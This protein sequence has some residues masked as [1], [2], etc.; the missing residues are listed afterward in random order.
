MH[1]DVIWQMSGSHIWLTSQHLNSL[2]SPTK[3]IEQQ[4]EK[5][6]SSG[7]FAHLCFLPSCCCHGAMVIIQE[8]NTGQS[9]KLLGYNYIPLQ[10]CKLISQIH[11]HSLKSS[12]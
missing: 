6:T 2:F 10:I 7:P 3:K 11:V 12:I 1:S 9:V 8:G 5:T 4:R